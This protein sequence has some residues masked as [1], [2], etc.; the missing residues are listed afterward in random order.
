MPATADQLTFLRLMIG[1]TSTDPSKQAFSDAA[2]NTLWDWAAG[3]Y[4]DDALILAQTKV[5]C[6]RGLLANS[7]KMVTYKQNQS[8]EN[9]S[10]IFKHVKQL[11]ERAESELAGLETSVLGTWRLGTMR[12][13]KPTRQKDI[14]DVLT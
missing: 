7:A 14:P 5:Y 4:S 10:D 8:S 12:K 9:Q 11:L 2:L 3:S 1:D 13:T 6:F